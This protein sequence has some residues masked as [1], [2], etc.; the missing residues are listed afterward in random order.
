M[1]F[2][3]TWIA[4]V[5]RA[6]ASGSVSAMVWRLTLAMLVLVWSVVAWIVLAPLKLLW[7]V[8]LRLVLR[9]AVPPVVDERLKSRGDILHE[10]GEFGPN[11]GELRMFTYVPHDLPPNAPLIVVLHGSGQSA[12]DYAYGAGW[13]DLADQHRFAVLCPEQTRANNGTRSFNWFHRVDAAREGGEA[14]S[15][16]QM[17][18]HTLIVNNLD[19]RRVFVTGLSSGGAMAVAMLATHPELFVAGAVVAGLPYGAA[20]G[21]TSALWSM[22]HGRAR[23]AQ[24]WGDDVRAGSGGNDGPWPR[25]SIW[26]GSADRVVRPICGEELVMQWTNVHGITGPPALAKTPDGRVYK[27]WQTPDGEAMVL[28]HSIDGMGHG[29]PIKTKGTDAC[30]DLGPYLLD[31]GI[32]SSFE[33]AHAWGVAA[34]QVERQRA[35]A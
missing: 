19:S 14:H 16:A 23:A 11:P 17:V 33:I 25:I 29:T 30:G 7:A 26:H 12:H 6:F 3:S 20:D 9:G 5:R 34:K 10:V 28:M 18:R 22:F 13:L 4:T 35:V 24:A 15:I 1:S 21:L 31:V 2:L 8:C 32:S 27:A